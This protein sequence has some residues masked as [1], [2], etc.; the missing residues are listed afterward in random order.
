V[1]P[2]SNGA[3]PVAAAPW[4]EGAKDRLLRVLLTDPDRAL[5]AVGDLEHS[6]GRLDQLHD[7]MQHQRRQLA[8]A[9]RR[10]RVAGLTPAQV[11]RLAGLGEGELV[12]LLAEHAPSPTPR[13]TTRPR[14]SPRP[15]TP[16][17]SGPSAP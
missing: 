14:P 3:A 2:E 9:A 13:A 4:S 8:D 5:H 11:A 7:T 10:L 16:G 6:Q 12:S 1:G 17:G 15:R